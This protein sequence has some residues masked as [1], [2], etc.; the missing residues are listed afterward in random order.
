MK[1][2]L[3]HLQNELNHFKNSKSKM[4]REKAQHYLNV[5][6]DKSIFDYNTYFYSNAIEI[7]LENI[8]KNITYMKEH[9]QSGKLF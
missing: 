8:E 7:I 6:N 9:E 3:R 2:R 4:N 5:L 1:I